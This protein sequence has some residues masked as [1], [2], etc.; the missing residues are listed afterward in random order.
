MPLAGS[1]F[2]ELKRCKDLSHLD[3]KLAPLHKSRKP[4]GF[5]RLG[6]QV[7]SNPESWSVSPVTSISAP[8]SFLL[9]IREFG[10]F[11]PANCPC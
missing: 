6:G 4:T 1:L 5:T 2:Q 8:P 10:L 9:E 7:H 11:E 3:S